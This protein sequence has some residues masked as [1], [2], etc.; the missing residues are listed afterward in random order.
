MVI[1][2]EIEFDS[3]LFAFLIRMYNCLQRENCKY[4]Q[5][6]SKKKAIFL[7]SNRQ[8]EIQADNNQDQVT[9]QG[10]QHPGRQLPY[11]LA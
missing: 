7:A 3:S 5:K 8:Q 11:F 1:V 10:N 6:Y 9:T 2:S 4:G